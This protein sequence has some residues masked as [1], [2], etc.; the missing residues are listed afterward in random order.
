MSRRREG[1][2]GATGQDDGRQDQC[3]ADGDRPEPVGGTEVPGLRDQSGDRVPETDADGG[4]DRQGGDRPPG[5]LG[6]QVPAGDGHGDREDAQT[7][8]LEAPPDEELGE[9]L[10]NRGHHT[11]GDDA[12][13]GEEDHIALPGPVGEPAHDRCHECTGQQG[14]RE[15]PF[16]RAERHMVG[17]GERG[18]E[19]SAEARDDRHQRTGGQQGGDQEPGVLPLRS[20]A[21][22]PLPGSVANRPTAQSS[23]LI[24]ASMSSAD[25]ITQ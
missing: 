19:G 2:V 22:A 6:G 10:R 4:G 8:A 15:Q 18:D 11:A 12:G 20:A 13:E 14:D 17:P 16:P 1:D 5:L 25:V 9:V 24:V 3:A 7:D 23:V 21:S